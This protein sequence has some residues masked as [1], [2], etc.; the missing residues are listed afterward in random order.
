MIL[1]DHRARDPH[2]DLLS[3]AR[4]HLAHEAMDDIHQT[5]AL[6]SFSIATAFLQQFSEH[7]SIE[8][9]DL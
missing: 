4:I 2:I 8:A 9:I 6:T 5:Q 3:F 1:H 7:P